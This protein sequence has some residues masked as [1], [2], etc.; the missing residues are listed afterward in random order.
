MRNYGINSQIV[1][2][3]FVNTIPT[4]FSSYINERR[5]ERDNIGPLKTLNGDG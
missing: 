2:I 4:S 1:F 3:R 5:I